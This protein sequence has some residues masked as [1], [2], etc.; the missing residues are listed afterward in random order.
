MKYNIFDTTGVDVI[1]KMSEQRSQNKRFKN[2]E[3]KKKKS[4]QQIAWKTKNTLDMQR[5]Q[6]NVKIKKKQ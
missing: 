4:I 6:Q 2:K 1:L 5:K 3:R